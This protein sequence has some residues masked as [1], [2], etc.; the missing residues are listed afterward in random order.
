[1]R[2]FYRWQILTC[3]VER[4]ET[5]GFF[6]WDSGRFNQRL[7]APLR[8]T[9]LSNA[10]SGFNGSCRLISVACFEI[11]SCAPAH[12]DLSVLPIYVARVP[13]APFAHCPR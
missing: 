7:F 6:A 1:M 2:K 9:M 3:H 4:S 8:M 11:D 13:A 12:F 10:K 5:S